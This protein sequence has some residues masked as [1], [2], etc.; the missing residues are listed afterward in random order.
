LKLINFIKRLKQMRT[1]EDCGNGTVNAR[2]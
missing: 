2:K 1:I